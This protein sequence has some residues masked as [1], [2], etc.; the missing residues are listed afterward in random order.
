MLSN[1]SIAIYH[2]KKENPNDSDILTM[3]TWPA[4]ASIPKIDEHICYHE[5]RG[6]VYGI[7][8]KVEH[9]HVL[10]YHNDLVGGTPEVN[11]SIWIELE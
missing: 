6:P 7:V 1:Q 4:G 5:E 3:L 8:R 11:V 9:E 2:Y 10:K